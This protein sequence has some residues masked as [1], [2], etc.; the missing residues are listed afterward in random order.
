VIRLFKGTGSGEVELVGAPAAREEWSDVRR[1]ACRLLRARSADD[2]AGILETLP[3]DL[4]EG[5][6]FFNDKFSVL[7]LR[8][9]LTQYVELAERE[10]D[11]AQRLAFRKIAETLTEIGPYIRFI[12]LELDSKSELVPVSNPELA[13][14]SESVELALADC[15]ELI[16]SR[17][18]T[19]GVDRVHTAF[20]G[21]LRAVCNAA[22]LPVAES[23]GMT[24]L[25][26]ALRENHPS[27]TRSGP[28]AE[29]IDRIV[30]PMATIL[31]SLNPLRNQATLAHPNDAVLEEAEAMLV[32]NSV[33][34]LLHYLNS[35]LR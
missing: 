18:A 22:S 11:S 27:F 5:T 33:R 9:P 32:I 25:F 13:I 16:R 10:E 12:L 23:A 26:K 7:R 1:S 30:R 14:T 28:R 4:Y 34:T 24:Q 29:D 2:A 19:S 31:D 21:Y 17:G 20:H 6:N 3:L 15:E 8:V 35:K